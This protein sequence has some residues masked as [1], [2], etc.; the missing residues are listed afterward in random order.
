VSFS[1]CLIIPIVTFYSSGITETVLTYD[2][3]YV[4]AANLFKSKGANVILSPPVRFTHSSFH[5]DTYL[6]VQTVDNP[7]ETGSFVYSA[8][9]FVKYAQD[10]ATSTGSTFVKYVNPKTKKKPSRLVNKMTTTQS[11]ALCRQRVES[12]RSLR[13]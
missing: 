3:Y 11:R 8:S 12:F 2:A 1:L 10:A 5:D 4:N 13:D 9:R 6:S 7:W